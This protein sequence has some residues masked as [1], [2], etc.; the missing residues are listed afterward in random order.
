M[1]NLFQSISPSKKGF[2]SWQ[3][4]QN[5]MPHRFNYTTNKSSCECVSCAKKIFLGQKAK[6]CQDCHS[7]V[8]LNC[9]LVNNCCLPVNY[10]RNSVFGSFNEDD[11][12]YEQS[13]DNVEPSAPDSSSIE[14][15]TDN[16]D[17]LDCDKFSFT[18][19]INEIL[20]RNKV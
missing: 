15:D 17:E 14:N 9:D 7:K 10:V 6:K 3:S 4:L 16:I 18:D 19:S 12:L 13:S 20:K 1:K 8:H 11:E 2:N 5:E